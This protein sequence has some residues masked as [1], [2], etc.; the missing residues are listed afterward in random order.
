M[1]A[2][3]NEYLAYG[4]VGRWG[5]EAGSVPF[6]LIGVLCVVVAYLIGSVNFAIIFSKLL[7]NDDVR[8]HGSGNAGSTNMLRTYGLKT[9]LLTF[10]CDFM[11]G[12]I[13]TLIGMFVMPY[14]LGFLYI[15][16][17]ACLIG[18]AFPIY[19]GFRGGKCVAA[20]AGVILVIN[21]MAFTLILLAF[22]FIVLLSH[23]I[24]LGS[25]L[26]AM[27]FPVANIIMPF[28]VSPAPPVGI[29]MSL[30][31]AALVIF[32]HRKNIVRLWNGNESKVSFKSKK[33]EKN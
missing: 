22:V 32:L 5:I 16:G 23:Y 9:A 15:T 11:K 4:L 1:E 13:S 20:M 2:F 14:W 3:F 28:Y 30:L 8:A 10:V 31:M 25:V 24:S 17:F 19:H 29:I 26:C 7:H 6:F 12:V 33:N 21:P 18:H 27:A